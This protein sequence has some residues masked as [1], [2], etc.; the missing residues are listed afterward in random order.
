MPWELGPLGLTMNKEP[1]ELRYAPGSLFLSV[2]KGG[3]VHPLYF[4][5]LNS[6]P[7]E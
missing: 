2:A 4:L 7:I 3:V 5:N 6:T 1:N